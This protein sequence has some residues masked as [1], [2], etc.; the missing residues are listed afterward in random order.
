M[1]PIGCHSPGRLPVIPQGVAELGERF[2]LGL[3]VL[4][5]A[6]L[7]GDGQSGATEDELSI[8][9]G[10]AEVLELRGRRPGLCRG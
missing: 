10:Y 1:R 8:A 3:P 4:V 5:G 7:L 6:D 2:V 9:G